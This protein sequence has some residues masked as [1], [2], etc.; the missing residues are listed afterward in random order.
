MKSYNNF[1]LVFQGPLHKNFIYGLLNNYITYTD[2]IIISYWDTDDK[3]L[4]NYIKDKGFILIENKFQSCFKEYNNQNLYYQTY[5]TLKGLEKVNTEF[6][7]KLRTDQW[8]GN[9][10]PFFEAVISNPEKYNCVNL[11][12]RPDKLYKFHP[13][14][15]I[16]GGLTKN[17][18]DTFNLT[19]YRIQNH[20]IPLISGAYMFTEDEEII[21]KEE[22]L[23]IIKIYSY[24]NPSRTLHTSYPN[25]PEIGS[26]QYLPGG[27]IGVVP[28]MVI[29]T[30]FLLSKKIFPYPNNS[31][32]L[33][34]SNFNIIKVEDMLPY[35]NKQGTNHIEHNSLEIHNIEQYG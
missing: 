16:I 1:T 21:T 34:K 14:D 11:H 20:Q 29:G 35:V 31:I 19:L 26:P 3:T 12:F 30:S 27:Y 25:T 33:V 28:E 17:I 24:N 13:S 9:L 5:T 22:L 23:K 18:L 7:I 6:V 4:L 32:N 8:F 15:K 10:I 2:N